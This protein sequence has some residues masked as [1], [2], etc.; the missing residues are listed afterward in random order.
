MKTLVLCLVLAIFAGLF[1]SC[2]KEGTPLTPEVYF[3]KMVTNGTFQITLP[4]TTYKV[5]M[6]KAQFDQLVLDSVSVKCTTVEQYTDTITQTI[7]LGKHTKVWDGTM[8]VLHSDYV[9]TFHI[10]SP[11]T[12][13]SV[14]GYITLLKTE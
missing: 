12:I 11:T 7:F 6:I 5:V 14:Y 8:S 10:N 13:N 3:N 4:D 2:G 1:T 9:L